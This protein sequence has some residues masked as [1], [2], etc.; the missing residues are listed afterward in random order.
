MNISRSAARSLAVLST[1]VWLVTVFESR[2]ITQLLVIRDKPNTRRPHCLAT[3][4][5]GAVL[6]PG[7]MNVLKYSF[8][9]KTE[10]IHSTDISWTLIDVFVKTS[11]DLSVCNRPK[12]L[13][14]R[15]FFYG[16]IL[17][18]KRQTVTLNMFILY[19]THLHFATEQNDRNIHDTTLSNAAMRELSP[20]NYKNIINFALQF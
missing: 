15:S 2:S 11:V 5:S 8:D 12:K 14:T 20:D 1:S 19:Y 17:Q 3:S 9:T 4:T 13:K 10:T 16:L 6:I 7:K 18:K